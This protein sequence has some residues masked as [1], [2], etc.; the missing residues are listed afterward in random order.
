M[1]AMQP[2]PGAL[3]GALGTLAVSAWEPARDALLGHPPVYAVRSLATLGARRAWGVRLS[4]RSALRWGLLARWLY[5]PAMGT[6][7]AALRPRLPASVRLGG[8][9]LGAAVALLEHVAFPLLRVTP[10]WRTWSLGEKAL[11]DLQVMLF[12]VVT[13]AV[14][15]RRTPPHDAKPRRVGVAGI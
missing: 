5:G 11:L 14:L 6:L 1:S 13:E 15:S 7:Y 8:L 9:T 10:P 3:A 12:G 2:A 4:P